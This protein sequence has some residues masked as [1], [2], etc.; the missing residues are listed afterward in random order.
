MT[1]LAAIP[2]Q[3]I[4]YNDALFLLRQLKGIKQKRVKNSSNFK[5]L[6]YLIE[7]FFEF[8]TT[9]S[10]DQTSQSQRAPSML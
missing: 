9:K 6:V 7:D 1:K 5:R 4:S 3:P 8:C 10:R 2:T